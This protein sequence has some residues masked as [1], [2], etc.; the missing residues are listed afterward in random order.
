M[1]PW[2]QK[3]NYYLFSCLLFL[4]SREI[5]AEAYNNVWML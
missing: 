4:I 1:S 3:K 2:K 5:W